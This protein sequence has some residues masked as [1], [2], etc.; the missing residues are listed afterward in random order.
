MPRKEKQHSCLICGK[1]SATVVCMHCFFNYDYR[2]YKVQEIEQ[3]ADMLVPHL[4][5]PMLDALT[6]PDEI[7]S[8]D[9]QSLFNW[10]PRFPRFS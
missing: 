7:S 4:Q 6:S 8:E 10:V 3:K 9:D 1:W 5:S 2:A